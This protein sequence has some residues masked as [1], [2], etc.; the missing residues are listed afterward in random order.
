MPTRKPGKYTHVKSDPHMTPA[1]LAE[2]KNELKRLKDSQP[3]LIAEVG[4]LASDGDF[5]ENAAYQTAKG[6]LRGLNQRLLDVGNMVKRAIIIEPGFNRG[7]V[8]LGSAVTVEKSGQRQTYRILG[9]SETDP[10][11]GVISQNSPLGAAL[12]GRST[13]EIVRVRLKDKETEYKIIEIE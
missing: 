5:S 2:L 1:K 3:S 10:A 4:R 9:S 12:L 6:R 13:G 8:G 11:R 7:V